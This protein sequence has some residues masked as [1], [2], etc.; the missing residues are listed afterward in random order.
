MLKNNINLNL[1]KVFYDV[2]KFGSF[3]KTAECTYT[4]QSAI[5]KAI[6]QLEKNLDVKLFYRKPHGVELT[7]A[8]KEILSYVEKVYDNLLL[9]E[10]S[11]KETENL[12]RGYLNV[13]LPTFISSFFFMDKII[14]FYKK[15]PNIKITLING[16][17]DSYLDLLNKHEIDFFIYSA[18][19]L[20]DIKN[21]NIEY[22]KLCSIKYTLFCKSDEYEKYKDIKTLKDIENA[23]LVLPAPGTNNRKF[24][25]E[26]FLKNNVKITKFINIHSSEGIITGVKNGLGLGYVISDI[27]KDDKNFKFI[28][29]DIPLHEEDI[30]LVYNKNFLNNAPLRFIKEYLKTDIK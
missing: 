1:Y 10:R 13:G 19:I 20:E 29:I 8:G 21:S 25:D 5:S 11:I 28:N 14:E 7:E 23:P 17:R 9:A 22:I 26:K 30:V 4:S 12:E 6:N 24:L 15:Y 18:P 2:C 3:S 27:I 16:N